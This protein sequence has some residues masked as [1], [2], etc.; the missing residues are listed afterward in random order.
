VTD[1]L[2][3]GEIHGTMEVP[4]FA[5]ELA[6]ARAPVTVA[7]ELPEDVQPGIDTYLATG[8]GLKVPSPLW[9]WQDGRAGQG[10]VALLDRL[11]GVDAHVVC[12]DGAWPD[13]A[14]RDAGMAANV[15]RVLDPR[16]ATI[17]LCGNLHARSDSPRWMTWH[18]RAHV[19]DLVAL[20]FSCDGGTAWN[21][22]GTAAGVHA[23]GATPRPYGITMYGQRDPHGFDGV[24][25]VG[26]VT[27]SLPL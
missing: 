11:R 7:L 8:D 15:L 2:V 18:L 6:V 20:D 21:H 9:D 13:D 24:Y 23:I 5:A 4:R 16:R 26:R 10:L 25:H 27:P 22:D 1:V 3:L 17:V 12:V 14:D 19:P